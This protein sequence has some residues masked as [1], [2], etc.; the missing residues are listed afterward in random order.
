M[1]KKQ[2][3]FVCIGAIHEDYNMQLENIKILNRTNPVLLKK[4]LGGVAYNLSKYLRF[5]SNNVKL[6]SL[7]ISSK[8]LSKLKK[9]KIVF[10]S[11][12][13]KRFERFYVSILN[14]NGKMIFGL[15]NTS[16]YEKFILNQLK[17]IKFNNSVIVLDLNFSKKIID[18][19][20]KE[21]FKNNII[22][23]CGTSS[24]K[25]YKIKNHLNTINF[26]ILNK[27]EFLTLT[28]NNNFNNSLD[29]IRKKNR[30]LCLVIT[31]G[32]YKVICLYKNIIYEAN[33][34]KTKVKNDNGAGDALSAIF[35][36]EICAT[37]SIYISLKKAVAAGT[38]SSEGKNI[39]EYKIY[40]ELLNKY[41]KKIIIRKTNA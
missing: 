20:I 24:S 28:K 14:N 3:K 41:S 2:N 11:F 39:D 18:K 6:T 40:N 8:T 33:T 9:Q 35:L 13:K 29:L 1:K 16:A 26:L 34:I 25:I 4:K 32:Q 23:V 36:G 21:N 7:N 12:S 31:N 5:Y 30:D 17:V 37:N 27:K 10:T 38:L 19:I 15:A 22:M